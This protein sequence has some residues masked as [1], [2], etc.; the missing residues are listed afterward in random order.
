MIQFPRILIARVVPLGSR[1]MPNSVWKRQRERQMRAGIQPDVVNIGCRWTVSQTKRQSDLD[2][3]MSAFDGSHW[4]DSE[5]IINVPNI[6]FSSFQFF[7]D[8]FNYS[9]FSVDASLPA[10]NQTLEI[11]LDWIKLQAD[12]AQL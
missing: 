12:L 3:V 2:G 8:Q 6:N 9:Q 7:P 11:F 10:F 4:V 1:V 5:D